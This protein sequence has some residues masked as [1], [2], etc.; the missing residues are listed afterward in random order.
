MNRIKCEI[1]RPHSGDD[2][3]DDSGL[4]GCDAVLLG[5]PFR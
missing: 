1:C 4:V 5:Q 2:D 3:D